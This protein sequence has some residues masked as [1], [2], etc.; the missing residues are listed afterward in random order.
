[1]AI[2]IT[3]NGKNA[4]KISSVTIKDEEYLQRYINDNPECIPLDE[5]QEDI[6]ILI[7]AREFETK[8]GSIDILLTD[9]TGSIYIVE[10]KLYKNPD[11][12]KVLAQVMD[13]GAA[14]WKGYTVPEDFINDIEIKIVKEKG[15][16]LRE[17]I[18]KTFKINDEAILQLLE[19]LKNNLNEGSFKYLILMDKLDDRLKD[20][21]I[22]MN[23]NSK[24]DIYAVELE[25]Y[26][27]EDLE[28]VIPKM[29]GSDVKKDLHSTSSD[30]IRYWDEESFFDTLRQKV[31]DDKTIDII[32]KI[33]D[34][35]KKES[36]KD[37][38]YTKT[39]SGTFNFI[40]PKDNSPYSLFNVSTDAK[41]RFFYLNE[42][43][44]WRNKLKS[45][46]IDIP[47]GK[48][49]F[50]FNIN[51]FN[52]RYNLENFLSLIKNTKSI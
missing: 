15:S 33:Y 52:E 24:F 5:L 41:I 17:K 44:E 23:Q 8:S 46:G 42:F 47:T 26:K 13:Y 1:M 43:K 28:I 10:T 21:I 7:L 51:E 29:F 32:K 49:E 45:A 38:F 12:R 9:K 37:P 14:L 40:L 11:K 22:Y 2:I 27:Y 31:S 25:M 30:T 4:K 39:K 16:S 18:N 50:E 35:V 34:I 19:N 3:K 36:I 20:L 48:N 6:E